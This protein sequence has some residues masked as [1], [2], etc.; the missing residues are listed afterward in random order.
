VFFLIIVAMLSIFAAYHWAIGLILS[1]GV[2][3]LIIPSYPLF[4][5]ILAYNFAEN[6]VFLL[7]VSYVLFLGHAPSALVVAMVTVCL[8]EE[9]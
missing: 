5:A 8:T 3:K 6:V 1:Y 2:V 7:S 9:K 4:L